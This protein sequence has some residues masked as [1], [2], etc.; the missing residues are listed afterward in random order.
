MPEYSI[1]VFVQR[2]N[3]WDNRFRDFQTKV[4]DRLHIDTSQVFEASDEDAK[5]ILEV[6]KE[7]KIKIILNKRSL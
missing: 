5:R 6:A 3:E 7:Y 1:V 2:D 4:L